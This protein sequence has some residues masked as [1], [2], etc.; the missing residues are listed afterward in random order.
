VIFSPSQRIKTVH[1][2]YFSSKLK[3]IHLLNQQGKDVLN[4]GI[5]NPD[6]PPSVQTLEKAEVSLKSADNHGYQS[7]LGLPELRR[8]FASWYHRF[9]DVELDPEKEILPLMGSKE[10]IFHIS[11]AFLNEGDE[12]LVPNPGYPAYAAVTKMLGGR[13]VYYNLSEEQGWYPD[14]PNLEKQDLTKV[15]IMWVNYPHM[16]TGARAT[17]EL[18]EEIVEFG[19]RNHILICHDNPYS[20]IQNDHPLSMLSVENAKENVLELNSLSKS[21]NMAGWRIGMLAGKAEYVAFVLKST[22]NVG[23]GMFKVV[24]EAAVEALRNE[25]SWY[26]K[27][28]KEYAERKK[29]AIE[30]FDLLQCSYSKN[31]SGLFVWGK[32]PEDQEDAFKF[33]DKI[34]YDSSVFITPGGVFGS[35]GKKYVRL[36]LCSDP[37]KLNE[38]L[39][40]INLTFNKRNN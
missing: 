3:E 29:I 22:S 30:I 27:L 28:N 23:S 15:K 7:Y 21:H 38:A 36:S 4:L 37:S 31:Q 8:A 5:G 34:L 20:F 11:M 26:R 2:Y 17:N 10:G 9:Y 12:V 18:F 33:S 32:I 35:Q 1:E 14:F 24:Q 40:R 16:P 13:V 6:N 25:P 39:D 19:N